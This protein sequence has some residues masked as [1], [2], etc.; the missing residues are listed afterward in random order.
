[1]GGMTGRDE[2]RK[3]IERLAGA[4]A[5]DECIAEKLGLLSPEHAS[6]ASRELARSDGFV[7]AS[8]M[9]SLC[10]AVKLVLRHR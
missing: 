8:D 5:C 9:C 3:L 1:M 10:G 4:P 2:V 7:R 6:R